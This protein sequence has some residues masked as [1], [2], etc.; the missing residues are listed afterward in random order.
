[1][2][3]LLLVILT[4]VSIVLCAR[5]VEERA[6]TRRWCQAMTDMVAAE[7]KG[8]AA[9]KTRF[10]EQVVQLWLDTCSRRFPDMTAHELNRPITSTSLDDSG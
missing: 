5:L 9:D 7:K 4:I 8:D 1:M 10:T 3:L 6:L 2:L